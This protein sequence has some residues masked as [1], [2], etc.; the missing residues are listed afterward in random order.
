MEALFLEHSFG[1]F[2]DKSPHAVGQ[3]HRREVANLRISWFGAGNASTSGLTSTRLLKDNNMYSAMVLMKARAW[4]D[5]LHV[6][7]K[8][9]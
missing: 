3:G 8:L 4:K 6:D 1:A 9:V 7:V 5:E 2:Y